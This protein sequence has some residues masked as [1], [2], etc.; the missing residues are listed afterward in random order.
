MD[1]EN[2][3]KTGTTTVGVVCRDGVVVAAD[4][5]ATAG[6]MVVSKSTEKIV[7]ITDKIV[8]T[9]AG[10]VSDI[11]L[12]IRIIKAQLKLDS[13]RKG[14]EP[15]V[16]ESANFMASLVYNNIRKMSIIPGVAHFLF[17]G[18]DNHGDALYDIFPDGSLTEI[19]DYICSGSGSVFAYGVLEAGYKHNLGVEEG[20][21]LAIK[22]VNAAMQRDVA[23]GQ[24]IDVV[25]VGKGEAKKVLTKMV[26][27]S[28]KI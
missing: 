3:R 2:I 23:S 27:Y 6:G 18:T 28:V 8:V 21:K 10:T 13:L 11:Q 1:K 25:V 5:R 15:K 26:D 14:I 17:A 9:T 22:A 4:K 20:T 12:L 19:D 7:H 16:K 24:G